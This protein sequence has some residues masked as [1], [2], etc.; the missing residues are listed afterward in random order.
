MPLHYIGERA[1]HDVG[2][3]KEF[4]VLRIAETMRADHLNLAKLSIHRQAHQ[5]DSDETRL[6][7]ACIAPIVTI[8]KAALL[9]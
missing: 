8:Q 2:N 1:V 3:F 7:S 5:G 6:S 4:L 9:D